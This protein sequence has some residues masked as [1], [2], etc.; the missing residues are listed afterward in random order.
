MTIFLASL[1]G[2]PPLGGWF[3]KFAAFRAVLDAGDEWAYALAVIGAVNTAIAAA[4][5]ITVMREIWMKPPPD[6]DDDADPH[7]RRR[8]GRARH[9]RR[10]HDRARRAARAR[11]P[12][13]RPPDLTGAARPLTGAAGAR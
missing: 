3:A 7:A 11:Q 9:H 8:S 1:A 13:R 6:G 4:Y 5:Y 12:L 10:R 2:I